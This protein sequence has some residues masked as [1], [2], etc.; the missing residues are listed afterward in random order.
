MGQNANMPEPVPYEKCE[1][2]VRAEVR[3]LT[4]N[5]RE[6]SA[7]QFDPDISVDPKKKAQA[8]EALEDELTKQYLVMLNRRGLIDLG[9]G[10]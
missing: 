1:E 10:S 9:M 2:I 5:L 8:E 4:S 6:I 7:S 3:T